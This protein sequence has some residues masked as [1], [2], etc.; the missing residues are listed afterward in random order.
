MTSSSSA[1]FWH[2]VISY[3]AMSL[4][5]NAI[6][7]LICSAA[8]AADYRVKPVR[9]LPIESYPSQM[10]T[11]GI[12]IAADPYNTDEKSY[13]VFDIK[14]LNS[15]GYFPVNII[16]Q[17]QTSSY[18]QLRTQNIVL[19]TSDAR[20]LY[21]TS[22]TLLVEDVIRA[23]FLSKL[24]KM[25]SR[26]QT[27][28]TKEGSPLIDFTTK[29]LKNEPIE[30]GATVNGFLFFY[31]AEKKKNI[32]GGSALIIP[33]LTVEGGQKGIGPFSIALHPAMN[34]QLQK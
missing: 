18:V 25:S 10:T 26:D 34:N 33:P 16:I 7:F 14:D 12:T 13:T 31:S 3:T 1:T 8:W 21:P 15:R 28:S 4:R 32:L 6:L 29:E 9:L 22:S 20:S 30:P 19:L 2:A 11:G 17:N 24:P 23:G 5:R 27:T